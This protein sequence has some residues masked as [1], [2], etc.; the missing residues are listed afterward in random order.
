MCFSFFDFFHPRIA[1]N[2]WTRW[3]T[4]CHRRH[5]PKIGHRY[6]WGQDIRGELVFLSAGW[7]LR[8]AL[9][10]G[11]GQSGYLNRANTRLIDWTGIPIMGDWDYSQ[12]LIPRIE[13]GRTPTRIQTKQF[14]FDFFD[15]SLDL[16]Q[17]TNHTTCRW[18]E[19][20][21]CPIENSDQWNTMTYYYSPVD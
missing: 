7:L 12:V 6:W 11:S 14:F 16:A 1:W 13:G 19:L 8:G 2:S 18:I 15:S 9:C 21:R 5:A 10:G 20:R 3:R 17:Y 4:P